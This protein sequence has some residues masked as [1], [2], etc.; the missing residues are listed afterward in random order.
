MEMGITIPENQQNDELCDMEVEMSK[1][2]NKMQ[3]EK[4]VTK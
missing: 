4:K 2:N 1:I 3:C